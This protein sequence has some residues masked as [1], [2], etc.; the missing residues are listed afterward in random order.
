MDGVLAAWLESEALQVLPYNIGG[1]FSLL[2]ISWTHG[3]S[4]RLKQALS[5]AKITGPAPAT[6]LLSRACPA[7]PP[8]ES[9]E[10]KGFFFPP[11]FLFSLIDLMP[12]SLVSLPW[13]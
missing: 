8:T 10:E 5:I 11:K 2:V 1:T 4:S 13:K 7:P 6:T 9:R 12:T 3:H